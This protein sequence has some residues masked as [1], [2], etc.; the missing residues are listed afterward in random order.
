MSMTVADRVRTYGRSSRIVG[1][2]VARGL[3]V[4]GMF[5]AHVG[6][7]ETF[8]WSPA[9]WL[10]LVNGRSSILFALLAGVSIAI[11]SGG[12]ERQEGVPLMQARLRILTR[13]A[14]I[15]VI[16]GLLEVLGTNVA[17]ILPYYA[18]LFVLTL[19]FL[20][21]SPRALLPLAA[22]LAIAMPLAVHVLAEW[23]RD[24]GSGQPIFI[25]ELLVTGFYPGLVWIVFVL[26]GLA[27]GRLDLAALRVQLSLLASGILLAAIGYGC[28]AVLA[29]REP[30]AIFTT[31]PHSGSPFEV[32]GSTG[33]A[34]G[35]LALSLLASRVIR[36]PLFPIAAVGGMALTAY[37][38]QIVTI[39]ALGIHVPG[40]TDNAAWGW[41]TLAA[42]VICSIWTLL[43]GRGPLERLLTW[44]SRRAAGMVPQRVPG[45][46]IPG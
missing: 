33:F 38:A 19:P 37:A 34:I 8:D 36:W 2:D 3:A 39:A 10:D 43:L 6:V 30:P 44:V 5:G 28:G 40:D 31:Y 27:I 7:F 35:V 41:F 15:F 12:T 13:A 1:V 32:V 45:P 16:G 42:L 26:T 29:G 20:R 17:V 14:L 11:I 21:W 23:F 18:V 22:A 25:V 9:T 4:L 24:V 46:A